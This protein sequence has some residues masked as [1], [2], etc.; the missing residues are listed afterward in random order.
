M[1]ARPR[2]SVLVAAVVAALAG[3]PASVRAQPGSMAGMAMDS[4]AEMHMPG[5]GRP[6]G[7]ASTAPADGETLTASPPTL[8]LAFRRPVQLQ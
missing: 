7:P 3:E 6:D 8:S 1:A 4:P 2:R 5:M